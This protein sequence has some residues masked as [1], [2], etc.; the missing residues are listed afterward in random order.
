MLYG[1]SRAGGRPSK[2]ILTESDLLSEIC[3]LSAL[4]FTLESYLRP[5]EHQDPKRPP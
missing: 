1:G 3:P 5:P 4:H 2:V